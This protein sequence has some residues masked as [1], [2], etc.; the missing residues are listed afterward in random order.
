MLA[1][2]VPVFT[3]SAELK[4]DEQEF[5]NQMAMIKSKY[6]S[7]S[8][9]QNNNLAEYEKF[10]DEIRS[11]W[12]KRNR[13][14]YAKLTLE[15]CGPFNSI[16][17]KEDR[18]HDVARQY[19]L[20]ALSEPNEI[21]LVTE[22]ELIGYV[23]TPTIT[24]LA[25]KGKEFE[26][27]RKIDADVRFHAWKRLLDTIDPNWDPNEVI[28]SPTGVSADFGLPSGIAPESVKDPKVRAEYATALEK[29]RQQIENHVKQ[30]QLR[31]WLKDY[32]KRNE[33]YIVHA[34]ST[35]PYNNEELQK[36]LNRFIKDK[37][38]RD[39]IITT[40]K[41]NIEKAEKEKVK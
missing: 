2:E 38:T 25:P 7:L 41:T 8:N 37:E 11:K 29:N 39:R 36:Y 33:L 40:V 23:M 10:A 12:S 20:S 34:Y 1:I 28:L 9:G 27:R 14:Y 21:T 4:V 30:H 24:S 17:F 31:Y 6:E 18:R 16:Y 19:A 22:L 35:P 32:P 5:K 26:E 3:L 13:E 15:I